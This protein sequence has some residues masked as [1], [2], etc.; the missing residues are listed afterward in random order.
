MLESELLDML[1]EEQKTIVFVTHDIEEAVTLSDRVYVMKAKPGEIA[2]E[3]NI[4]LETSSN[5]I[6][7]RRM[8]RHFNDYYKQIWTSIANPQQ[9]TESK[10][11]L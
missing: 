7:T 3:I 9:Q 8:S 1:R 6:P 10:G 11:A 4:D 2:Q 5:D